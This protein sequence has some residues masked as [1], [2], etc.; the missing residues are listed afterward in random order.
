VNEEDVMNGFSAYLLFKSLFFLIPNILSISIPFSLIMSIMLA[1]GELSNNGELIAIK[2]GGYS[3]YEITIYLFLFSIILCFFLLISN[4][5]LSPYGVKKSRENVIKMFTRMTNI[6]LK[7][8][9]FVDLS[10]FTIYSE[11]IHKDGKI[12][13]I[14]LTRKT[15]KEENTPFS[16]ISISAKK[17]IYKTIK[18]KGI[19]IDMFDGRFSQIDLENDSVYIWGDFDK[20]STFIPFKINDDKKRTIPPKE[21]TNN[22]ILKIIAIS[23]DKNYIL[24]CLQELY[25]RIFLSLTPIA[26]FIFA[27][28]LA[29]IF[30][31]ES[32]SF[33]FFISL[34]TIFIYYG[35]FVFSRFFS[36][37]NLWSF[38]WILTTPFLLTFVSG[39]WLWKTKLT[40]K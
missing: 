37:K 39:I 30:E 20:Y 28:A 19:R 8:K 9:T 23:K 6:R 24:N 22:E 32:K 18:E 14:L 21:L 26:F 36:E 15:E 33:G 16:I 38:P 7:S 11:K 35:L 27:S 31:R 34:L 12:D 25:S 3:Y 29:F 2:A 1:I 13:N 4:S 17:G 40:R 10:N 5:W